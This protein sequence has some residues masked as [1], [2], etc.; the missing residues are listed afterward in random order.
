MLQ[1]KP[2]EVTLLDSHKQ[3]VDIIDVNYPLVKLADSIDW[4]AI[5]EELAEAYPATTGNPNKLICLMVGLHYLRYMFN[6][7]EDTVEWAYIENPYYQYFC[8]G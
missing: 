7:S 1:E 6:I 2:K 5:E 3:L 4:D 8:G